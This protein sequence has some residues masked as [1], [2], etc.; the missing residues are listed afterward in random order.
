MEDDTP[1]SGEWRCTIDTHACTPHKNSTHIKRVVI[2]PRE[3]IF[4]NPEQH[5]RDICTPVSIA[6]AVEFTIAKERQQPKCPS[7]DGW[8]NKTTKYM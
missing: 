2:W 3:Y 5:L 4:Q 7:G 1:S 8:I 6:A